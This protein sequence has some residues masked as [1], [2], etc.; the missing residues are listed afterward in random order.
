MYS[1]QWAGTVGHSGSQ[2]GNDVTLNLNRKRNNK[3]H[4]CVG[5]E[6]V[7]VGVHNYC[8]EELLSIDFLPFFFFFYF[9]CRYS[10]CVYL[11]SGV[12]MSSSAPIMSPVVSCMGLEPKSM[13]VMP[14]SIVIVLFLFL[15][16]WVGWVCFCCCCCCAVSVT[17]QFFTVQLD[18]LLLMW[19]QVSIDRIESRNSNVTELFAYFLYY[20]LR[21]SSSIDVNGADKMRRESC[22]WNLKIDYSIFS[23]TFCVVLYGRSRVKWLSNGEYVKIYTQRMYVCMYVHNCNGYIEFI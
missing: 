22:V 10:V 18:L 17:V 4:H 6:W 21:L 2:W 1:V 16:L 11:S 5:V 15:W 3:R 20:F 9:C 13:D 19:L 8:C 12:S 7:V 23:K 14:S